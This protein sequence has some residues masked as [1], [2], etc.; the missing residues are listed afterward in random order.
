MSASY[1]LQLQ[2]ST[3][4]KLWERC[5]VSSYVP[6]QEDVEF[7]YTRLLDLKDAKVTVRAMEIP[8]DFNASLLPSHEE[9]PSEFPSHD[10][11]TLPEENERREKYEQFINQLCEMER[12]RVALK[13][14]SKK[15]A[16]SKP[17][18]KPKYTTALTDE[19]LHLIGYANDRNISMERRAWVQDLLHELDPENSVPEDENQIVTS[20]AE[21]AP[22]GW[23]LTPVLA[24]ARGSLGSRI[25][26]DSSN[27][28]KWERLL[29]TDLYPDLI[30]IRRITTNG[31]TFE[32]PESDKLLQTVVHW[33]IASQDAKI[34]DGMTPFLVGLEKGLTN[35]LHTLRS[36]RVGERLLDMSDTSN[37]QVQVHKLIEYIESQCL[38]SAETD[39]EVQPISISVF[40]KFLGYAFKASKIPR[41]A[42]VM[43]EKIPLIV[44]RWVKAQYGFKTDAPPAVPAWKELWELVMRDKPTAIRINHF[45]ASMDVWDPVASVSIIGQDRS[46]IAQEWMR[47]YLDTQVI[48]GESFKVRSVILHD[49]MRKWC[50]RYLPESIFVTHFSA[51]NI[52]PILTKRG[53]PTTKLKNGRYVTGIRFKNVVGSEEELAGETV[54]TEEEIRAA[55]ALKEANTVQFTTVTQ[56]NED[57]SKTKKRVVERTV[58]AE[59]DGARIEHYFAASVTTETIHLGTL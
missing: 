8:E 41:E 44:E 29:G 40:H 49:Q 19:P 33:Y 1:L 57:G 43:D 59:K 22:F 58:V 6:P 50:F 2:I 52:G 38:G 39:A 42:H 28:L 51:N 46:A 5:L 18:S 32:G 37:P 15:S 10:L 31:W 14:L 17:D 53:F 21:N 7:Y 24:S 20:D 16:L 56:D 11:E 34:S 3:P 47:I 23:I 13:N 12:S 35:I 55:E 9:A 54:A 30:V 36:V 26:L 25:L 45:L 48:R 27:G 4:E